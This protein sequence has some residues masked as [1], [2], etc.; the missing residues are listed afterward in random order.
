V[1]SV[2]LHDT[3]DEIDTILK[4]YGFEFLPLSSKYCI[5]KLVRNTLLSNP[6]YLLQVIMNSI[7]K[8]PRVLYKILLRYEIIEDPSK[9]YLVTGSYIRKHNSFVH[10]INE[11]SPDP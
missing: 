4:P 9:P 6:G 3:R 8:D 5:K 7:R 10:S 2:E 11:V 1:I